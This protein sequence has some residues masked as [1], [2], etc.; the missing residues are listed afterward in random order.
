MAHKQQRERGGHANG[1]SQTNKQT[2]M[3][4]NL[5]LHSTDLWSVTWQPYCH[6]NQAVKSEWEVRSKMTDWL[7]NVKFPVPRPTKARMVRVDTVTWKV[8][9]HTLLQM[10][11][12]NVWVA[13]SMDIHTYTYKFT[14]VILLILIMQSTTKRTL[15]EFLGQELVN[16]YF[17]L[18]F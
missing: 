8:P 7:I 2:N 17:R 5:Q 14:I 10:V 12:T 16:F 3:I 9:L 4:I 1:W 11:Y 15:Q 18:L 6:N 13:I